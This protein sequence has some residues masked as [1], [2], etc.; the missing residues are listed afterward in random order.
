MGIQ[1]EVQGHRTLCA[2]ASAPAEK[3]WRRLSFSPLPGHMP[4]FQPA[5]TPVTEFTCAARPFIRGR[6]LFPNYWRTSSCRI[7]VRLGDSPTYGHQPGYWFLS[8]LPSRNPSIYRY[9][10]GW[11]VA[12]GPEHLGHLLLVH[13]ENLGY[14]GHSVADRGEALSTC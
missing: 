3:P 1:Y 9:P 5:P 11:W 14:P 7:S 2:S 6:R 12:S 10:A 4:A 8:R 13:L